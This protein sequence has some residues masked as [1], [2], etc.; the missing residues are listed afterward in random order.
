[1]AST[2][3]NLEQIA[4]RYRSRQTNRTIVHP[5]LPQPESVDDPSSTTV[6]DSHTFVVAA[7]TQ[8]GMLEG[9]LLPPGK[10]HFSEVAFSRQAVKQINSL[11][12]RPLFCCICGD[13]VDMTSLIAAGETK[14][15]RRDRWTVKE[16][17]ELQE[18]QFR[19]V[20]KE[21]SQLH[22]DIALVCLCGNHD[23]GNRPTKASIERY[24]NLFGDDYLAFWANGTY[25]IILNSSLISSYKGDG[26]DDP[27]I[28]EHY[29]NQWNWL[30]ERLTYATSSKQARSIFIYSHHPWFLY[31]EDEDETQLPGR[32]MYWPDEWGPK[33]AGFEGFPE[34]YF[35]IPIKQRRKY[36]QLFQKH[37]VKACFSGHFHQNVVS[38]TSWGMAMIITGPLSLVLPS[39]G[40]PQR[41]DPNQTLGFRVV[42]VKHGDET[43]FATEYVGLSHEG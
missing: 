43:T 5:T 9:N 41:D 3:S 8:L 2:S 35:P 37:N 20:Q 17:D 14:R 16:C 25:N 33:P 4:Q 13:L 22:K 10:K 30:V 11:E 39:N 19:V 12:P 31:K 28:V 40:N 36:L 42:T 7:D 32:I 21:W 6:A 24:T 1:M 29:R 18:Q 38:H 15:F 34:S 27:E 23:V 26:S